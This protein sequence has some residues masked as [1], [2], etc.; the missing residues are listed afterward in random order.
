MPIKSTIKN[1]EHFIIHRI[2]HVDDS[3]HRLAL[4]IA[5][6]LF[7]AWTPTIGYQ[8]VLVLALATV[9]RANKVVGLPLVWISNPFTFVIIY[10][11]NYW[12][13]HKILE[14]FGERPDFTY[15][16]LIKEMNK[17]GEIGYNIFN[18]EFWH[19]AWTLLLKFLDIA[20]DLWIGSVI[21]GA[22]LGAIGYYVSYHFIVW[23]RTKTSRGRLHVLQ[24]L[25][26]RKSK[27][28]AVR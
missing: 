26:N 17:M 23:Y 28:K 3:P 21:V 9:F 22:V 20:A 25:H 2:L 7:I 5:I 16:Y 12:I 15:Q 6:G 1:I 24:M 11:P 13:G 8:M 14:L 19:S 27:G 10:W 4:G 18:S